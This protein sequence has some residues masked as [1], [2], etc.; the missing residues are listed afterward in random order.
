M[1]ASSFSLFLYFFVPALLC[2]EDGQKILM[3]QGRARRARQTQGT[4]LRSLN[5]QE[6]PEAILDIFIEGRAVAL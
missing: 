1:P 4:T 2:K 6:I 5:M 3:R